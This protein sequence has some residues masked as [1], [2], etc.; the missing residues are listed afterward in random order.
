MILYCIIGKVQPR[1]GLGGLRR[2]ASP[3]FAFAHPELFRFNPAGWNF[4][5]QVKTKA[6]IAAMSIV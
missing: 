2:F 4:N 5:G 6:K 3:G 1:S